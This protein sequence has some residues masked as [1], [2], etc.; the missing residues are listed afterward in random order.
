MR[1]Y[2]I[3]P[4]HSDIVVTDHQYQNY[5]HDYHL[6][7]NMKSAL[8]KIMVVAIDNQ[9]LKCAKDL[10]MGYIKKAS[11]ELTDWN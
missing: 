1:A 4:P 3:K 10:I 7:K 6:V 2:P 11:V 9:W 8:K 5:L